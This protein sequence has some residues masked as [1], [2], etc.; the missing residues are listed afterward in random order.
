MN[1]RVHFIGRAK[2]HQP[3]SRKS[4]VCARR[5]VLKV[6]RIHLSRK[7]S[8][9]CQGE[10]EAHN[11][12]SLPNHTPIPVMEAVG[13]AI[14]ILALIKPTAEAI[15]TLWT[16]AENFSGDASRFRLRFAV[17]ITRLNS[18]ERVLFEADKFP[19]VQGR[20]FDHL[21]P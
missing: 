3:L 4:T 11:L 21:P 18:F 17:Q 20:L 2:S 19:L 14:G 9:C 10:A 16:S 5:H 12:T 8:T 13:L 6:Q 15:S 1:I 7:H